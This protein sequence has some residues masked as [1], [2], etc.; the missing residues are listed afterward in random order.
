MAQS[1]KERIKYLKD[2]DEEGYMKLLE[3]TKNKRLLEMV[4]VTDSA[5]E[6]LGSKIKVSR[7]QHRGVAERQRSAQFARPQPSVPC[8]STH[9]RLT[10][11][12]LHPGASGRAAEIIRDGGCRRRARSCCWR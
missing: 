3:H 9:L 10:P 6:S 7:A 8:N 1:E 2:N 12:P 4:R 11:R 5:L